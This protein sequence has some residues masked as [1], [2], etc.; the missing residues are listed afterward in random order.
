[1]VFVDAAVMCPLEFTVKFEV[2]EVE[3]SG[4]VND[5]YNTIKGQTATDKFAVSKL[6]AGLA[7]K[8]FTN[9]PK[10]TFKSSQM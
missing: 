10:S 7:F 2:K 3:V 4:L 8:D 9:V 6:R 5:A 1:M